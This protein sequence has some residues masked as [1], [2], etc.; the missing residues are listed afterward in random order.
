MFKDAIARDLGLYGNI[1][2]RIAST[3]DGHTDKKSANVNKSQKNG[4][5]WLVVKI[6]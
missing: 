2:L 6:S 4:R 5:E 3:I 1:E